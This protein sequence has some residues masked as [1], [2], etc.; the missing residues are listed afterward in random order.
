MNVDD[1]STNHQKDIIV[2][3]RKIM[4]YLAVRVWLTSLPTRQVSAPSPTVVSAS[5]YSHK[6]RLVTFPFF[7]LSQPPI[8]W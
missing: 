6:S 2:N 3:C 8:N 1:R 4:V 7:K 5:P